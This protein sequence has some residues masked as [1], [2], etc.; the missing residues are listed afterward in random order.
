MGSKKSKKKKQA[1]H[2]RVRVGLQKKR[3]KK[4]VPVVLPGTTDRCGNA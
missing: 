3:N 2:T 4:P 1:P